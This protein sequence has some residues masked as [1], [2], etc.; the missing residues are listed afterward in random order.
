MQGNLYVG[1]YELGAQFPPSLNTADDPT[2]LKPFESPSCYGVSCAT[3]GLLSTGSI[4]SGTT[5][6]NPTKSVA[7]STWNWLYN[8]LWRVSTTTLYWGAPFYDDVYF[9]HGLGKLQVDNTILGVF[10]C[11]QGQLWLLTATGSYFITNAGSW[12]EQDF[13]A[14]HFNQELYTSSTTYALVLNGMPVVSNAKGVFIWDGNSLKELT[15]PVRTS[16]GSFSSVA[17]T[18]DY[19][20]QKIVGASKYVIDTLTG[21]LFDYGTS[22]FLYTSRTLSQLRGYEP[23]TVNSL[24]LAY[25][26]SSVADGT[27]SWESKSEDNDWHTEEDIEIKSDQPDKTRVEV[28]ILNP[29]RTCHKFAIRL[30]GL[31]SNIRIKTIYL[32]VVGLAVEGAS[33]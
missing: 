9:P 2:T 22:G 13:E 4:I 25:D 15:R 17:I 20:L 6:D 18:A 31:S 1:M 24:A 16:L 7:G 33:E 10:P 27:I 21:K 23:L 3:D 26:L 19:A 8:R 5:R 12:S 11:F 14:R 32:N 28:Q 29:N 30:T